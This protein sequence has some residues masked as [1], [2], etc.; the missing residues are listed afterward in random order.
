MIG[1]PAF[2]GR[3]QRNQLL[4]CLVNSLQINADDILRIWRT[5]G[6]GS[7]LEAQLPNG[8]VDMLNGA[9]GDRRSYIVNNNWVLRES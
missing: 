6:I 4:T 7:V 3:C 2:S 8:I 9:G 5:E 1:R